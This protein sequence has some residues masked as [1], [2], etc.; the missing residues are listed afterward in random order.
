MSVPRRNLDYGDFS[1][2]C[3][4]LCLEGPTHPAH[5]VSMTLT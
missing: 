4:L 1:S 5:G 3:G 2:C